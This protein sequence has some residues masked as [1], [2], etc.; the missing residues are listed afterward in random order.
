MALLERVADRAQIARRPRIVGEPDQAAVPEVV[1]HVRHE[2]A[3]ARIANL[4]RVDIA[5]THG[6]DEQFVLYVRRLAVSEDEELVAPGGRAGR[7]PRHELLDA[8]VP[9]LEPRDHR[10]SVARVEMPRSAP[11]RRARDRRSIDDRDDTIGRR[12]LALEHLRIRA[13]RALLEH[14][15]AGN[16]RGVLEYLVRVEARDDP[17]RGVGEHVSPKGGARLADEELVRRDERESPAIVEET[18]PALHERRVQIEPPRG[19]DEAPSQPLFVPRRQPRGGDVRRIPDDEGE[20]L[21][22]AQVPDGIV[23]HQE[24]GLDDV[25]IEVALREG[26]RTCRLTAAR[27]DPRA[28]LHATGSTS[29]P[30]MDAS[31][32]STNARACRTRRSRRP[33]RSNALARRSIAATRNTPAPHAGSSSRRTVGSPSV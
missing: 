1:V 14:R 33:S 22:G 5:P 23:V 13:G 27:R 29:T 12:A 26:I 24:V 8:R 20:P 17:Q 30:K 11:Q 19:R 31:T 32:A 15:D 28:R 25:A 3:E 2:R 21:P 16:G 6:R 4:E 9:G 18:E 10:S 7:H